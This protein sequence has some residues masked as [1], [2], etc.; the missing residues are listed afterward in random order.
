MRTHALQIHRQHL[1]KTLRIPFNTQG[2]GHKRREIL[3]RHLVTFVPFVAIAWTFAPT[4]ALIF[5]RSTGSGGRQT[6]VRRE[7]RETSDLIEGIL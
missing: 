1:A 3:K 5:G 2:I 6:V 4:G 7:E